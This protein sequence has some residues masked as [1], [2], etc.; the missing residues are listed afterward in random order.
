MTGERYIMIGDAFAFIDPVFS[1][2]VYLA[3]NSAFHGA[4]TVDTCLREPQRAAQA[5]KRFDAEIRRGID[6]FSWYIYRATAPAFRGLFMSPNNKF[7]VVEAL[8]SLL[9]GDVFGR[10]P[11]GPSLIFFKLV[12]YLKSLF[13]LK[14]SVQAWRGR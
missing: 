11:I 5:L 3:M 2:G 6:T 1:T 14:A 4:D 7:R 10:S 9:A 13:M 12:Y 8:V